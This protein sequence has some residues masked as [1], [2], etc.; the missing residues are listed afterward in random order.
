MVKVECNPNKCTCQWI[1][2]EMEALQKWLLFLLLQGIILQILLKYITRNG[3]TVKVKKT[4]ITKP[5]GTKHTEVEEEI[6]DG[7]NR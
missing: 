2:V 3:K 4:T 7:G 5:D 6:L 1:Q